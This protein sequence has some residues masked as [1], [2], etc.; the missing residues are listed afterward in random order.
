MENNK[1]ELN[2]L[3]LVAI[4]LKGKKIIASVTALTAIFVIIYSL[5]LPN[6][7][8][9]SALLNPIKSKVLRME[10]LKILAV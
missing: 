8:E 6:L 4:F 3:D 7:Y 2:I 9:S 5:T 1:D 10:L